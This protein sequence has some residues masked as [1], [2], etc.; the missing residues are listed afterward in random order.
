[1]RFRRLLLLPLVLVAACADG[2]LLDLLEEDPLVLLH[3]QPCEIGVP[4]DQALAQ[5]DA[6]MAGVTALEGEGALRSGQATALRNHLE[7]AS[8]QIPD[9]YCAATAQLEAFRRQVESFRG[10]GF[11]SDRQM[12]PLLVPLRFL[13]PAEPRP[14][15]IDEMYAPGVSGELRTVMIGGTEVTY[16]VIDGLAIYQSDM[17]FGYADEFEASVGSSAGPVTSADQTGPGEIAASGICNLSPLSCDRWTDGIIGYDFADDWGSYDRNVMMRTS[18][19]AAIRHWEEQ[20]GMRFE[21]RSDGERLVFRNAGGCSSHIGRKVVTG[22]EPQYINLSINCGYDVVIHE[23][24]HAVGLHHEQNR[25]DRNSHVTIDFGAIEVDRQHNF[26]QYGLLGRDVGPYDWESIMHYPCTAFQ[27]DGVTRNTLTPL[28]GGVD[29]AWLGL[30]DYL[31]EGDIFGVYR[32]YPPTFAI[33]G[34]SPGDVADRFLLELDFDY[35][36]PRDDHI[37]W[38]SDRLPD[39]IGTG[40][41]LAI[42]A[43]SLPP[44]PHT[45]T[46]RVRVLDVTL[47]SGSIALTLR[48]D[49]PVV[50]LGP[51]R[52][53]DL[54]RLFLVEATVS[55][56]EDGSCPPDVC[57]YEWSPAPQQDLVNRAGYRLR[58]AGPA[59]ISLTVTD[60]AGASTTASVI[61]DVV[62][63]PPDLVVVA[64]TAGSTFAEGSTAYFSAYA[65]DLNYGTGP[66]AERIPCDRLRWSS[67][68]P[69]DVWSTA[70]RCYGVVEFGSVGPRTITVTA[71]DPDDWTF[72]TT[73]DV[74]ISVVSC[75]TN[76]APDVTLSLDTRPELDGSRYTPTFTGPGYYL[77]TEI[78]VDGYL[79]DSEPDSPLTYEFRLRTWCLGGSCPEIPLQ[80]GSVEIRAGRTFPEG[81]TLQFRPGDHVAAWDFC[82]TVALPHTLILE[83]TDSRGATT[84]RAQTIHLACSL[85]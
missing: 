73:T 77:T 16:E 58:P 13:M 83:V 49:A 28:R 30:L 54:N 80:S 9:S 50:D 25:D 65:T 56:T 6:L 15:D 78:R 11:L 26:F 32:L 10:A 66:G 63:T 37:V 45:I 46:A 67:S 69:S 61:V 34:A 8:R 48:N 38:T 1:M 20:T 14:G 18:I 27:R 36:T 47:S 84:T 24:G 2:Q 81:V 35:G 62:N 71:H 33:T 76:C 44:G 4:D 72:V 60:G 12:S 3:A 22:I 82:T 7:N 23:I 43:T 53:V 39:P 74:A 17:I 55:D 85:I 5:I 68:D 79:F 40:P 31:S 42:T 19:T 52:P 51:D 75:G 41:E 57:T 70:D 29:C 64:P 59:T 21:R